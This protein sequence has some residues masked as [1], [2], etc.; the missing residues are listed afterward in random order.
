[1]PSEAT[2]PATARCLSCGYLLR[3]LPSPV[4]PE[5][6]RTFDPADTTTYDLRPPD[7]RRR[8][9]IKRIAF[10]VIGFIALWVAFGPRALLKGKLEFKCSVCG[11]TTTVYRWEPKR[12]RW[13]SGRYPGFHWTARTPATPTG[14][15][16]PCR[17]HSDNVSVRFD[18]YNGGWCSGTGT[19]G[20]GAVLLL[21][22]LGTTV[23]TAPEVLKQ[24]MDPL[25]N[26]IRV[27]SLVP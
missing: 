22:G 10:A 4:C 26:S 12:P 2:I 17:V 24:L 16:P 21:N 8:R 20:A 1:M 11:E 27:L 13:I 15:V 6:G 18:L 9:K 23:E 5:C 3:G 19:S 25:N 7:W 14:N